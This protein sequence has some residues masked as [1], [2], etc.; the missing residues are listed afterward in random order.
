MVVLLDSYRA[1][2]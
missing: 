2:T 1:N